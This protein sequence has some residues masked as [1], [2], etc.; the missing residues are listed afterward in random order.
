MRDIYTIRTPEHVDFEFELAGVSARAL[1]LLVDLAVMAALML[2]AVLGVVSV[3]L[4]LGGLAA[5]MYFVSAFAVQWGYGALCEWRWAGQTV[6]K[7]LLGIRVLQTGG[8]RITLM[9]AVIRNLVRVVDIL[10][11]FYLVGG[12]S[13]LLDPRGRRLGDWAAGT[14]VVRQRRSP[15]PA[16]VVAPMERYN[17]FI[18]DPAVAHA[19]RR[20]TAPERDAMMGLALRREG[21]PLAVRYALFSKLAQH[22]ERRLGLPR[23]DHFSEERYVLNL[24]AVLLGL[25]ERAA[26]ESPASDRSEC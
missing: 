12:T 26:R 13:A 17:S 14:I 10:P 3:G 1:A 18:H 19:G 23:P 2:V 21:L 7:R 22:L 16:A 15:R 11:A 9:Q 20:I 8:T 4:V 25:S 6:G 24:T 5:A